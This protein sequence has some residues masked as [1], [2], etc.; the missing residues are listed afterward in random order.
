[1][2]YTCAYMCIHTSLFYALKAY[3]FIKTKYWIYLIQR[4][5]LLA[6]RNEGQERNSD[7]RTDISADRAGRD[8]T[9]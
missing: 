3:G 4:T 8:N 6:E 7:E 9:G 1:M 2:K 5:I